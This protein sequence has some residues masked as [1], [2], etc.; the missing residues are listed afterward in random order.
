MATATVTTTIEKLD[1]LTDQVAQAISIAD[2][3]RHSAP[4][5]LRP[6]TLDHAG[7]LLDTIL[8]D[9]DLGVGALRSAAGA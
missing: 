1:T 6:D 5:M 7:G 4:D 2:L 3:I 9:I 8:R